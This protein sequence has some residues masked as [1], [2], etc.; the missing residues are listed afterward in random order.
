MMAVSTQ[1][2]EEY[3]NIFVP[4][5]CSGGQREEPPLFVSHQKP[6]LRQNAEHRVA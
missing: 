1:I 3:K 6:R 5:G 4:A 2:T